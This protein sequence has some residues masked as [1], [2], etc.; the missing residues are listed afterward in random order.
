MA[1]LCPEP[2][3]LFLGGPVVAAPV[4][5]RALRGSVRG[6]AFCVSRALFVRANGSAVFCVRCFLCG[7]EGNC[8]PLLEGFDFC[9]SKSAATTDVT[10]LV[11][12][13]VPLCRNGRPTSRFDSSVISWLCYSACGT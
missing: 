9:V 3:F 1:L 2:R 4:C 5:G 13:A 12:A 8:L 11:M 6:Y 10:L 7:R